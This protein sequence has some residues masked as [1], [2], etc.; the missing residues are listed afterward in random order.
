MSK[1]SSKLAAGVRKVKAEQEAAPAAP[2]T[3]KPEARRQ[4]RPAGERRPVH[5]ELHPARVWPD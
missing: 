3:S 1:L 4:A 5:S 2:G